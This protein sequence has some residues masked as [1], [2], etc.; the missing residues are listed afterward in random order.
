MKSNRR[1]QIV[2]TAARLFREKGYVDVTMRDLANELD[3]RASSLYNHIASKD[4]ILSDIVM[5]LAR[6]FTTHIHRAKE[7]EG[8]AIE[9]LKAII[10][11]HVDTTY[12]N[13]DFLACMNKEWKYLNTRDKKEYVR[14]R[15]AY[16][17]DF[18]AI[19]KEGMESGE[20]YRRSYRITGNSILS[21]LR[22]FYHWYDSIPDLSK[23]E[24]KETLYKNLI[25]GIASASS[26]LE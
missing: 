10:A 22:T 17:D 12:S 2:Q 15:T 4:T 13:S 25:L 14:L 1:A 21:I 19:L 11:M 16:E 3:I 7:G 26:V 20:I 24:V 9:K 5:G 23:E 8:S 6:D 18:F